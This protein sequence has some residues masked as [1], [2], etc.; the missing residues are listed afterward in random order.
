[1]L[2]DVGCPLRLRKAFFFEKKN[3]KIFGP[4]LWGAVLNYVDLA[5]VLVVAISALLGL[6]RGLVREALGVVS[7]VVAAYG[8]YRFGPQAVPL[9]EE[10]LG[11]PDMAQPAAYVGVFVVLL[12]V[13]SLAS[14]L[15]GRMVRVSALGGLDRTLG[16]VFGVLRGAA[17]LVA[18]YI[19]LAEVLPPER[20]PPEAVQART[21]PLIYAGAV[22]AA[23]HIPEAYRPRVA[24]PPSGPP[25]TE[26]QLLH[27]TP[28]GRAL[29]PAP[30]RP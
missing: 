11:N 21:L 19:P 9:A 16:L 26:A 4:G 29:G 15:V 17:I 18:V 20:W 28:E 1:M 8:A 25:T 24:E 6:S 5:V 30:A 7:W 23:S 14:N 10:A 2:A 27:A 12:I 13:L 3:Q 22:W